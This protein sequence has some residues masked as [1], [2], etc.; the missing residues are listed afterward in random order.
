MNF[1]TPAAFF[2]A[3]AIPVVILFYL[4]K[5]KRVIHLVSSTLLWQK[6]LAESQ[7]SAPFQKLRKNWLLFIQLLLIVLLVFALARPF[8]AAAS[9]AAELRVVILDGSASMKATDEKPSRFE[10]AKTDALKWVDG[11][12][13]TDQM[14]VILAA[15]D[16]QVR[17]S[18]TSDKAALRRALLSCAPSDTPTRL[19]P[20]LRIAESLVRDRTGAEVHLFSD[21]VAPGLE[22][23]ENKGLPLVYHRIG[24]SGENLAITALDLR[25]NPES[26]KERALYAS[27]SNLGTNKQSATVELL[28]QDRSLESRVLNLD[29]GASEPLLFTVSQERDALFTVRIKTEDNLASDNHASV[30]SVLPRPVK[31]L[32]VTGGNRFLEKA[33]NAIPNLQTTIVPGLADT[34][35]A[36]D[37]AVLDNVVPLR[38]PRGNVLAIHVPNTNW[39]PQLQTLES[40]LIAD[41]RAAHP[42][43]RYATFEN[44]QIRQSYGVRAPAW[45]VSLVDAPQHSLIIAGE[46]GAQRVVWVGFDLL[47]SN[48]PLRVS[49]PI[50]MANAIEW[51]SPASERERMMVKTGQPIRLV[52]PTPGQTARVRTPGGSER[53]IKQPSG[54]SELLFAET[55]AQGVYQITA[56]TNLFQVSA[57]LLDPAESRISPRAEL[58]LGQHARV[59]AT[60]RQSEN[61]ELWRTFAVLG[62]FVLLFEWWFYH[63]RSV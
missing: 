7:A 34:A 26:P 51:L 42:L 12:D 55:D 29:G 21:G 47:E 41:W 49:F 53:E 19:A 33:L 50:F 48:W 2:F 63:R 59:A 30:A 58:Q 44:V 40:P 61:H 10:K 56:G 13:Q 3:A 8:F 25:A 20:A 57:N 60:K 24:Q 46:L 18:A 23:F 54:S 1:L 38:W 9:K 62:L 32:L 27:I 14:V 5:R 4:L 52:L 15:Q 16:T 17:Q 45:G 28:L 22:E 37:L 6:F 43:L 39:F 36:Y 35:E 31:V 11:L